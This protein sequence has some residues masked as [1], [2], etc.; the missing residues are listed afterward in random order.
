V[1]AMQ[2]QSK[3]IVVVV[4]SKKMDAGVGGKINNRRFYLKG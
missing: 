2:W 3:K 1:E 4:F